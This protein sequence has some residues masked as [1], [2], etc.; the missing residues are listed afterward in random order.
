MKL[1]DVL[2]AKELADPNWL[3]QL[4][5]E[6]IKRTRFWWRLYPGLLSHGFR[7]L[8]GLNWLKRIVCFPAAMAGWFL[9]MVSSFMA[10]TSLKN[11]ATDYWPRAERGEF[12]DLELERA[13]GDA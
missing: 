10:Y 6:H 8:A 12:K 5:N 4:I 11:G 3:K 9:A 13:T 7:R 2:S 1:A